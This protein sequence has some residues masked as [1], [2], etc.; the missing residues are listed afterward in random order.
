MAWNSARYCAFRSCRAF[1]AVG[2]LEPDLAQPLGLEL[3]LRQ[4]HAAVEH[5]RVARMRPPSRSKRPMP[6][7]ATRAPLAS[8]RLES[9][10]KR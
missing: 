4:R 3:L 6:S 9:K 10:L 5:L 1:S 8:G 7:K 2:I